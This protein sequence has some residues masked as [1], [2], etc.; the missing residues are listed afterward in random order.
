MIEYLYGANGG[1][2]TRVRRAFRWVVTFRDFPAGSW[3]V[4]DSEGLIKDALTLFTKGRAEFYLNSEKR[5][6]RVP[7]IL[8]TEHEAFPPGGWFK[9]IYV[10]PTTRLCIPRKPNGGK[11][12]VVSKISLR[13]GEHITLPGEKKYLVCLGQVSVNSK[14]IDEERTFTT[15][16]E[17]TLTAVSDTLLLEFID[18]T[19]R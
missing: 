8:S 17:S 12:P 1:D 10:E 9:L 6:D 2:Q 3:Q 13:S 16:S 15:P 11:L 14:I 5:A 19:P 4:I 18:E 7:G